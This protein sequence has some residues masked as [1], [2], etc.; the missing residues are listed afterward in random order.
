M[1]EP[2]G[3]DMKAAYASKWLTLTLCQFVM[4]SSGTLYLFPVYSPLLKKNLDLTQE[5]TNA[6]GSAAHFGA[7]FSV[8]GGMFFD[9]Y[10]S[11]A[12]LALG[13]AL[14]TIGYL[15]MAATIE[16]WAP[17]SR[18]FA[19]FAAWTFGTGCSTSL[20]A[21]LGANYATFEDSKTHGRLVGLL[22]AFFG[23]SSGCLS[24]VYDVFFTR[25]AWFLVFVAFFSGGVDVAASRLVGHPKYL[26]LPSATSAGVGDDTLGDRDRDRDRAGATAAYPLGR[27][28]G[29]GSGRTW[30]GTFSD[31]LGGGAASDAK[32]ANGLALCA[33]TAVFVAMSAF[34]LQVFG[35]SVALAAACLCVLAA[36]ATCQCGVLLGG[37]GRLIYGRTEMD[38]VDASAVAA[39]ASGF[40]GVGPVALLSS[41]DFW[42]LFLALALGLGSGVTVMNNLSQVVSSFPSLAA[43]A[44]ATTHSLLKVLACG[45]RAA[46]AVKAASGGS[47]SPRRASPG[48]RSGSSF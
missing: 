24:L 32:L 11:R 1:S 48:W 25:P 42:L 12:T 23:L 40:D 33:V 10:G 22:V 27:G 16:G 28:S 3:G 20:T 37:S 7:F 19:S 2:T 5:A 21:A 29:G 41:L 18:A 9:A 15:M 14:K 8:F 45:S 46:S 39:R 34:A 6:V 43:T 13:G 31:A 4:L 17:R 35:E 26:A 44:A 38:N 30:M 47:R 36:L